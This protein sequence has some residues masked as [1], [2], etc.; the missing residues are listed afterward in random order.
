MDLDAL[1]PIFVCVVLPVMIVWLVSRVRINETNRKAEILLKAVES[2]AAVDPNLLSPAGKQKTLKEKLL[3][4][5]NGACIT[6]LLG[7]MLLIGGCL[8]CNAFGW[9]INAGPVAALPVMG[10]ILLAIG[11]A[12]FIVYFTGKKMLAKEIEAEEMKHTEAN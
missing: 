4:T 5:L 7:V 11:I 12:L 3:G 6:S 2:G 8:Y 9:G 1:I 10:G